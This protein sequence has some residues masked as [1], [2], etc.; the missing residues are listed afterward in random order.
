MFA[1]TAFG[2]WVSI[3]AVIL[4][5]KCLGSLS[6]ALV[7]TGIISFALRDDS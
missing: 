7:L 3:W 2:I 1:V 4:E 6:L 5:S